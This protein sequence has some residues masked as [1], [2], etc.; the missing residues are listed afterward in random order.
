VHKLNQWKNTKSVLSWFNKVTDKSQYS[1]IAFDVLDFYPS[2]SIDLLKAALDFASKY[3][4]VTDTEREIILHAKK[5]CLYNSGKH[6]RKKSSS[7]LFDV[8]MHGIAL[9]VQNHV[10]WSDLYCYTL[11]ITMKHGN[12]FGLYRDDGL[13]I[14]KATPRQIEL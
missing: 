7:N 2:I 9:M 8:T 14:I 4:N 1:F 12:K 5:S 13:G 11:I 10:N 3:D 6:R